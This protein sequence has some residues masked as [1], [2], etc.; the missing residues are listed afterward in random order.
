MPLPN[1]RAPESGEEAGGRMSFFEHLAELRTRL[2]HACGAIAIG[3]FIGVYIAKHVLEFVARP[4][5]TALTNAHL[6]GHLYWTH[7]AGILNLVITLGLYIGIVIASPYVLY[8]VWLFVAPGLYKHERKAVVAF[9]APAVAL[10]LSGIAFAYYVVLPY[11]FKFLVNFQSTE[12]FK[13]MISGNEYFDLVLDVLLGVGLVFELP[14][15]V[16][17]LSVFGIV[18]PQFLWRNFR[19]AILIIAVVAAIITPTP[20]ATTMLV[21]MAPMILLYAV[22]IGVSWVVVRRKQRAELARQGA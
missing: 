5:M 21:F 10:F 12:I 22:G 2:I 18:T 14:V 19:Y 7:P 6:E 11:L 20:D 8:Q 13:P 4:M 3:A 9:I 1:F 16:F 15:L 17:L